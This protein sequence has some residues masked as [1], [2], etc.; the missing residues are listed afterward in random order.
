[1][2][3]MAND[4]ERSVAEYRRRL[5]RHQLLTTAARILSE[6][7]PDAVRI[8]RVAALSGITR[9]SVYKH[10]A[11]RQELLLGVLDELDEAFQRPLQDFLRGDWSD[12]SANMHGVFDAFFD[13]A[14]E[15]G[16]GAWTL[17]NA[18]GTDPK[19]RQRSR[20]IIERFANPVRDH[21]MEIT[22][23]DQAR[24]TFYTLMFQSVANTGIQLWLSGGATR[25][26]T[27]QCMHDCCRALILDLASSKPGAL[28]SSSFLRAIR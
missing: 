1:M 8:P 28:E 7:G 26:T 25:E 18:G 9:P 15:W 12:P 6:D 5:R 14:A 3:S 13:C 27:A 2:G 4:V 11:N 16:L 17:L 23:A 19:T 22:G 24:A 21:M 20:E 10:F